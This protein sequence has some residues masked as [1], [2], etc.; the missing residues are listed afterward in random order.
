MVKQNF[1]EFLDLSTRYHGVSGQPLVQFMFYGNGQG[2][3][4]AYGTGVDF[5][6]T[7]PIGVSNGIHTLTFCEISNNLTWYIDGTIHGNF[8]DPNP[9]AVGVT[10]FSASHASNFDN[11]KVFDGIPAFEQMQPGAIEPPAPTPFPYY[12]QTDP[13]WKNEIYDKADIWSPTAVSFERWGCAV[14]DMSMILKYHGIN[15]LPDGHEST[16]GN[17]NAWLKSQPDGYIRDGML[18]WHAISRATKWAHTQDSAVPTL[19]YQ[20]GG[21]SLS[22]LQTELDA[23]RPA[24]LDV[25][26][27]FV[28]GYKF[29][30]P[31][32]YL[33]RDPFYETKTTLGSYSNTFASIRKFYPTSS[34]LSYISVYA[35]PDISATLDHGA[36]QVGIQ[37][38]ITDPLTGNSS[39][40]FSYLELYQPNDGIYEL[41]LTQNSPGEGTFVIYAYNE[42][43]EQTNLSQTVLFRQSPISF[44]IH[45]SKQGA[46]TIERELN[47]RYLQAEVSQFYGPGKNLLALLANSEREYPSN[48]LL[49]SRSFKQ[50]MMN[51][52]VHQKQILPAD[53]ALLLSDSQLLYNQLY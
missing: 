2:F 28:V 5:T 47:F 31:A 24:I 46:S 33:I 8:T 18:N 3:T 21:N 16:P 50:F 22:E 11:F 34:D 45:F 53:Y 17:L 48:T 41:T 26:G 29:T 10:D 4:H 43:G 13:R 39:S 49:S 36:P 40:P 12:L 1:E 27:H 52:Q 25:T 7:F 19:E 15:T 14:T 9:I 23:H 44:R 20:I 51:L 38:P 6:G 32:T 37:D 35:D 30:S 42:F